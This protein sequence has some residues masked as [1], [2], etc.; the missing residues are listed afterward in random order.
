M[1]QLARKLA[2]AAVLAGLPVMMA[3][4]QV[5]PATNVAV[6]PNQQS[7]VAPFSF[8]AE[9]PR[10]FLADTKLVFR[11]RLY[12]LDRDRDQKQDNV[13]FAA[14]GA[15]Q[16]MSAWAFDRFQLRATLFTSQD[17]YGPSDK[18][19]TLLFLPGRKD[20]PFWARPMQCFASQKMT[21]C[22]QGGSFLNFPILVAMTFAWCPIPLRQ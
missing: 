9:R 2:L 14:G 4:A 1:M 16:Y 20:S 6:E 22:A 18:D 17:V 13:G 19:G 11:P 5:A 21:S 15:L 10:A 3:Q 7:E 8:A 12:Y